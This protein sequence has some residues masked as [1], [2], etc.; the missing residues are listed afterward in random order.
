MVSTWPRIA[1]CR[2]TLEAQLILL[3][4]NSSNN[5]TDH[6]QL[7]DYFLLIFVPL[8]FGRFN[9]HVWKWVEKTA[10]KFSF[11]TQLTQIHSPPALNSS[12]EQRETNCSAFLTL[13][14]FFFSSIMLHCRTK[15]SDY[16]VVSY[17][18][19]PLP[20]LNTSGTLRTTRT[21]LPPI[22][23]GQMIPLCNR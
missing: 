9:N 23:K 18:D 14:P 7:Y 20:K 4:N 1:Q 2:H 22:R 3:W 21:D 15:F 19:F 17:F 11:R 13:S 10:W 5:R 16:Y 12:I 6:L 8:R